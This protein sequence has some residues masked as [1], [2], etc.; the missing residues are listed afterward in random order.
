MNASLYYYK[1][2]SL[3]QRH[4]SI[5]SGSRRWRR[6]PTYRG[7]QSDFHTHA[8]DLPPQMGGC[9]PSGGAAQQACSQRVDQGPWPLAMPD[10][11]ETSQPA[12]DDAP[13]EALARVLRHRQAILSVNPWAGEPFELALRSALS[14]MIT[15]HH[16][17]SPPGSAA[18]LLYL[19]DRISVPRDMSLHAARALRQALTQTAASDP[20]VHDSAAPAAVP[21]P[22]RHRRDQDP[23][24]FKRLTDL[25][26]ASPA[27]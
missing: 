11:P 9:Y 18:A 17:S 20:R 15:G 1:G 6:R 26:T 22:S 24:A 25:A 8:H 2:Y 23:L 13:A 12:S 10:D 5:A 3:R 19:R 21:L 14:T 7:T 4:A 27:G 16:C